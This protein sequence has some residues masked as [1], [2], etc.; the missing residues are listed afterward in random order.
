MAIN[1]WG[2]KQEI[3]DVIPAGGLL[4]TYGGE[5]A[6]KQY[7]VWVKTING[8][9]YYHAEP[10]F[11][12]IMIAW[13]K[14]HQDLEYYIDIGLPVGVVWDNGNQ[15]Y[16][17]VD[18]D[19]LRRWIELES[20]DYWKLSKKRAA[21]AIKAKEEQEALKK[22]EEAIKA[23]EKQFEGA[24]PGKLGKKGGKKGQEV[25]IA[26]T[27]SQLQ[28]EELRSHRTVVDILKERAKKTAEEEAKAERAE[29]AMLKKAGI[30]EE[31][32]PLQPV[33]VIP[34]NSNSAAWL[35]EWANKSGL[36]STVV[37]KGIILPIDKLEACINAARSSGYSFRKKVSPQAGD[38]TVSKVV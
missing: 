11:Q 18:L 25:F 9:I 23:V 15:T 38:L 6:I 24:D 4:S 17:E 26:D 3:P 14:F 16:R 22:K 20:P 21:K 7:R 19:T 10:D 27:T 33:M 37:S 30:T 12:R 36:H 5:K 2:K 29:K 31:S 1:L 35:V 32:N 13:R 28:A 34:L 8:K